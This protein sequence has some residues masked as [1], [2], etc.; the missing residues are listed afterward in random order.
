[1]PL[2]TNVLLIQV[3]GMS[4]LVVLAWRRTPSTIGRQLSASASGATAQLILVS[5]ARQKGANQVGREGRHGQD[6]DQPLH[7]QVESDDRDLRHQEAN[8]A[9]YE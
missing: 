7:L 3:A 8:A 1:M 4:L 2:A 9:R 5:G 6:R